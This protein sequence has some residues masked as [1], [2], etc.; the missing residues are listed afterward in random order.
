M[1][2]NREPYLDLMTFGEVARPLL[3][4]LF[5][6]LVGLPEEWIA[7]GAT[8]DELNLTV[9]DFDW[10]EVAWC[11]G[12]TGAFGLPPEELLSEDSRTRITRDGLGRTMKLIK[13]SAT[14]P[15]PL[16]HPVSTA[17][18]WEKWKP[19]FQFREERVDEA[20][21]VAASAVRERGGIVLAALPGGF[22]TPRELMGE[23]AL[24]YACA[25]EPELIEDM[26]ETCADT[27]L[28]VLDRILDK[29]QVDVLHVHEDMAGKSGPLFGPRQVDAFLV[30][31]Y[32]KVWD[33][34]RQHGVRLFSQDSDGNINAVIPNFIQAG[35]NCFYPC[36]PAAGMDSVALRKQYGEAFAIKGGIDKHVLRQDKAAILRELEYKLQPMMWRGTAFALDH[37]IPNG[38]P[39]ELYRYYVKTAKELLGI[40]EGPKPG[41][42]RRMAF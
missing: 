26:L 33:V 4:E 13:Q 40:P 27:T 24:C 17:S 14:L 42:W 37:R 31:Y 36:E 5:G 21:V 30:P 34:C 18:D 7:Q 22:D 19:F 2:W 28:K 25:D 3:T 39:I 12:G 20:Q 11:G 29:V 1:Q 9:F 38:T 35:I 8:E 32:R 15:L 6:P 41:K 23:E 16:D 10:V